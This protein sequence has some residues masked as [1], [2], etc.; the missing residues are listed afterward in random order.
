M[1]GMRH[2][3]AIAPGSQTIA[4][5][6]GPRLSGIATAA[7]VNRSAGRNRAR[8]R[9]MAWRPSRPPA[10]RGSS[11]RQHFQVHLW[12]HVLMLVLFSL[13]LCRGAVAVC[14]NRK[15]SGHAG[16]DTHGDGFARLHDQELVVAMQVD[17]DYLVASPDQA[18]FFML[19]DPDGGW[20]GGDFALHDRQRHLPFRSL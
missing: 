8:R 1:A 20:F 18:D 11:L 14:G 16:V 9:H 10:G 15:T 4:P 19:P 5:P 6:S 17:I 7:A 12:R 3:A 2:R 13:V